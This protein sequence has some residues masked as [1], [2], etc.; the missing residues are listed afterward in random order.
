MTDF[1]DRY[2]LE[3]HWFFWNTAYGNF[4]TAAAKSDGLAVVAFIFQASDKNPFY[5]PLDVSFK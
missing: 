3:M 2:S 1:L 5:Q 4:D